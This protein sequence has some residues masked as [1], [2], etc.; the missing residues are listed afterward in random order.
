MLQYRNLLPAC[1]RIIV[2]VLL[3]QG[4]LQFCTYS[5]EFVGFILIKSRLEYITSGLVAGTA[6]FNSN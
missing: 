3:C 2:K 4:M 5:L 1:L 6:Y